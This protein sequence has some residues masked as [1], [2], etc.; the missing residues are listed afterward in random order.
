M[1]L[2][3]RLHLATRERHTVSAMERRPLHAPFGSLSTSSAISADGPRTVTWSTTTLTPRCVPR[4]PPAFSFAG[5]SRTHPDAGAVGAYG[6]KSCNYDVAFVRSRTTCAL[7]V[8]VL[9]LY[10]LPHRHTLGRH[11]THWPIP[12][13][14][15]IGQHLPSFAL[16]G[17]VRCCPAHYPRTAL[18]MVAERH[19][20]SA[21]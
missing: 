2:G 14:V 3:L 5:C 17:M 7:V 16:S 12:T 21:L 15:P 18:V 4:L 13:L 1:Q 9:A 11:L 10:L 6:T 20:F 8:P 19:A